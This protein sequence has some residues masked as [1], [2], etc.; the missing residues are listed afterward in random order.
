MTPDSPIRR[1]HCACIVGFSALCGSVSLIYPFGRDQ[2][3][4]GYAGWVL[5][6]GGMPYR[7][8]LVIKPP[9]T[10]VV[11]T[12]A[13]GLFGVNTWAI[14]AL[15]LGWT[16]ATS[17][18]IAAIAHELWARRDI[19]FA[20]GL[21]YPFLYYQ[22]DYWN[23]AQTDGWMVLPLALGLWM[24]LRGG[25]ALGADPSGAFGRWVIAG[26]FVGVAVL[27]KY[28]AILMG[29]PL[30]VA[31]AFIAQN[32]GMR[33]WWGPLFVA[34]GSAAALVGCWLW[35]LAFG[36]WEA[37][38]EIQ[39]DM[40]VPYAQ[41][42]SDEGS[43][44]DMLARLLRLRGLRADLL[45]LTIAGPLAL[46]PAV[47]GA[48]R[49]GPNGMWGLAIVLASWLCALANVV[50]QGKFF[51][52]HYQPLAGPSAL[53]MGLGS[54][55]IFQVTL[56]DRTRRTQTWAALG[57]IGALVAVTPLGGRLADLARVSTGAQSLDAYIAS[58]RE[59]SLPTY[60]V[61]EV[62]RAAA[63]ARE[64]TTEQDR[65][66]VWSFEPT[67]N[68]R[69]ARQT[70]SRYATNGAFRPHWRNPSRDAE[71]L[72]ALHE[73]PPTLFI[74]GSKDRFLGLKGTY[75]DSATLL[76]DFEALDAFVKKRYTLAVRAGR[77]A[78]WRLDP[79]SRR[80]AL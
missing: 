30:I 24:T 79:A 22:L 80:R 11:H 38:T 43:L 3:T 75:A 48:R 73:H 23:T 59:Y 51:E 21:A 74:V 72:Q 71:L 33:A 4:Y 15:D 18:A 60:S 52:Y 44:V 25:R 10:I 66:F 77:Y 34:I 68:V 28:T 61:E 19:A 53:L 49:L 12:A 7:D 35:L 67:I 56:G 58:R 64:L 16:A 41:R 27:F 9:M 29:L 47:L 78:I 36:A 1:F 5:L 76:K 13:M 63:L 14:R 2:G 54:C 20:A 45:P 62:R 6:D 50:V 46:I 42:R 40:V 32:Y 39:L 8:V 69:A 65:V 17:L 55:W 70:V 57:F 26:C 37:F 31:F